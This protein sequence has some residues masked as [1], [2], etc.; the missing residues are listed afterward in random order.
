MRFTG[1]AAWWVQRASAIYMLGFAIFLLAT[2]AFNP[3]HDYAQWHHWVRQP[4]I[5]ISLATFFA[6]LLSHMW[7]GLRDVL[8]D[9]AKPPAL[10]RVLLAAVGAGLLAIAGS[11]L[12]ILI[13]LPR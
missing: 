2:F 7:V 3:V 12:W 10:Q 11:V 9:Y 6:A 8:L 5:A 4:G 1:L 13:S